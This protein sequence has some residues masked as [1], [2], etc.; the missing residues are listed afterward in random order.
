MYAIIKTG[1]KQYRVAQGET[2]LVERL[3]DAEGA[4][5]ELQPL[6]YVDGDN[7]VDG[8]ALSKVKVSA[9]IVAHERGPKLRIVKFKPKRGY[10]RRNGHRQELT[11][12]EIASI[13]SGSGSRSRAKAKATEEVGS[14]S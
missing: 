3:P 4:T 10:K 6:L 1:G 14:G 12:I 9:R 2:L 11:R 8:E 7:V 13:G 5:V